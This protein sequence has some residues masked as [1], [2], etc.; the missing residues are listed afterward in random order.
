MKIQLTSVLVDD[1]AKALDFYT[2]V[3]GF[4]KKHDIPCGEFRWLTVVSLQGSA[5]VELLLEP[6]SFAPARTYQK[7]LFDAG[8]PLA[9]FGVE[10]I[11]QDYERMKNLG[12]VFKSE[13]AT[14]GPVTVAVFEDTCG[15]LIQMVQA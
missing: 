3:L 7:A 11:Q 13:P 8:I 14:M 2:R 12:V 9:A 4:V 10:N 1:Q 15:N 5:D 6:M